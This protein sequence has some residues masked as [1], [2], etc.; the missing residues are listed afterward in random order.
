MPSLPLK[1]GCDLAESS[2]LSDL[3]DALGN[4]LHDEADLRGIE[5]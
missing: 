5:R 4:L 3:A 2:D 1:E